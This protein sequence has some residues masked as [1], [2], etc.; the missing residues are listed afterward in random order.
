M[1]MILREECPEDFFQWVQSGADYNAWN[2]EILADNIK[3]LLGE[4]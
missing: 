4:Y 2:I 3:R 1:T